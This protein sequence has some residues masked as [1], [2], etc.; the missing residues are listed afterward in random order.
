MKKLSSVFEPLGHY[1][2]Q[3]LAYPGTRDR[4]QHSVHLDS[5]Y[6]EWNQNSSSLGTEIVARKPVCILNLEEWESETDFTTLKTSL[7]SRPS[8]DIYVTR[9]RRR[10]ER[11]KIGKICILILSEDN[12]F[13]DGVP[14][15]KLFRRIC[16]AYRKCE[17]D[18]SAESEKLLNCLNGVGCGRQ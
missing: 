16:V 9:R 2:G 10:W 3:K 18:S 17:E 11:V 6:L 5:P 14:H 1:V 12:N 4:G 15:L 13:P 8:L 7:P